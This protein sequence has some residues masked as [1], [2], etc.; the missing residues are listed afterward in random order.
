[1]FQFFPHIGSKSC[2][3]MLE[4]RVFQ[5]RILGGLGFRGGFWVGFG[6]DEGASVA[7]G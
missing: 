7:G 1:M 2:S 6:V 4:R 5:W 3:C